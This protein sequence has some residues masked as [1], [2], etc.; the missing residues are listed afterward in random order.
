MGKVCPFGSS[1]KVALLLL[2][3]TVIK[4]FFIWRERISE[5]SLFAPRIFYAVSEVIMAGKYDRNI[6]VDLLRQM[7]A[8]IKE[9]GK[10]R[11][12]QRSDF[13]EEEVVAIKAHLGP[14]PRALEAAGLKEARSDD[15]AALNREKRVRAKRRAREFK[16][17]NK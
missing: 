16:N 7:Q 12:P 6:C 17:N 11:F 8:K 14:W 2:P 1:P 4:A 10:D 15:R 13:T 5:V 9:A 3:E